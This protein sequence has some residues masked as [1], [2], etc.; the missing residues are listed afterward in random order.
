MSGIRTC[1]GESISLW[2]EGSACRMDSSYRV[3]FITVPWKQY[4]VFCSF[5]IFYFYFS[6]IFSSERQGGGCRSGQLDTANVSYLKLRFLRYSS[7]RD[8]DRLGKTKAAKYAN[9]SSI[10]QP[11]ENLLSHFYRISSSEQPT[12]VRL[13]L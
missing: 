6:F 10:N 8:R 13:L 12:R 2:N 7:H 1:L 4:N 3:E 11:R 9:A 5:I